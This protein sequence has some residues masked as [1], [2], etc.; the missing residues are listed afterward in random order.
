MTKINVLFVAALALTMAACGPTI[1]AKPG[2]GQA[3]F[4]STFN[5]CKYE[6]M[7]ATP[8]NSPFADPILTAFE[9]NDL[10]KMC[11]QAE[12]WSIVQK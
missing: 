6:A 11:M 10:T 7:R 1:F 4:N 9:R 12:G 5:R 3:E 8:M 2:A